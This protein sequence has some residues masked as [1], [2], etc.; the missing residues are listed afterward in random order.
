MKYCDFPLMLKTLPAV[1]AKAVMLAAGGIVEVTEDPLVVVAL[2]VVA[3]VAGAVV[4]AIFVSL[5]KISG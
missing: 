1:L 3:V 5:I 2:D 4:V